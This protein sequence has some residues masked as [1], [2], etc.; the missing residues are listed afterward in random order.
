MSDDWGLTGSSCL[1]VDDNGNDREILRRVLER[2][3]AAV[4]E[5]ASAPRGLAEATRARNA[6]RPFDLVLVAAAMS[7]IDGFEFAEHLK[8]HAKEFAGTILVVG[9]RNVARDVKR[10]EAI[11]IGATVAKPLSHEAISAALNAVRRTPNRPAQPPPVTANPAERRRRILVVEDTNDIAWMIRA[12]VEGPR[13]EVDVATNGSIA[14]DLVRIT[15]YDLVL[16]DLMMPQF[17]GYWTA[18]EI[19]K[20]EQANGRRPV[21]IIA[22]TAYVDETPEKAFAARFNG[23]L[24]KPFERPALLKMIDHHLARVRPRPTGDDAAPAS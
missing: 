3:G 19:R 15:A 1:V 23:Y 4:V 10:A 12:M 14:V 5:A 17:D 24:R 8:P 13:Y 11:G 2:A 21:P 20:W 18:R 9:G 6:R 16:M 22:I 7:P